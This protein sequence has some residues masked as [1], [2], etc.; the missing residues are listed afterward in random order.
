MKNKKSET[1][2]DVL[3]QR[4]GN[5][6]YVFSEMNGKFIYSPLPEGVDPRE[7][8]LELYHIIEE[9][10]EKVS[11]LSSKKSKKGPEIAA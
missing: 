2:S 8:S 4:L 3:F 11:K 1:Q 9:H 5:V 6:W 7:T 10:M